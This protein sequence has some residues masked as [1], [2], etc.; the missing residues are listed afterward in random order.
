L[1]LEAPSGSQLVPGLY[2]GANRWPFNGPGPGLTLS[3]NHRGNNRNSGYF[4]VL[5]AV[6]G[7]GNTL[8]RFAVNFRQYDEGNPNNWVDGQFRFNSLVPEPSICALL[9]LA[10][11]AMPPRRRRERNLLR[12]LL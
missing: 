7:T 10:S 3:G 2:T 4:T 6:F 9:A 11:L 1:E 8:N 12:P 5:E